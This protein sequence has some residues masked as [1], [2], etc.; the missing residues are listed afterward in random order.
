MN[1]LKRK[2]PQELD[3]SLLIQ[4][5][6]KLRLLCNQPLIQSHQIHDGHYNICSSCWSCVK[7]GKFVRLPT[8]SWANGCWIGPVPPQLS[9]LTYAEE[10]VIARAHATKCWTK[11]NGSSR[12]KGQTAQRS[13]SGNVCIHPHEITRI[14]T[15]L[16]RPINAL[17]DE[18]I[19]IFVS[20][21]RP[22][23]EDMF[24]KTPLIVRRGYI[25]RVLQ[26]LKQHN[27]LY[28][29][30]EIDLAALAEYPDD[31]DGQPKFPV[32][33]QT[34][35]ATINGQSATYTGHGIDTTEAIFAGHDSGDDG[36]IPI[37]VTGKVD[38]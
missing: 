15:H 30:V 1:M 10:L 4:S 11:L 2:H 6:D 25:L 17:Y 32:Q 21:G 35:N 29:D 34:P 28:S 31:E 8:L 33:F 23:T 26:W 22:A 5:T 20:E 36:G 7:G 12:S 9:Q 18:I 19:V 14:A 24:K 3:I 27:P 16:P 13:A 37:S 38:A